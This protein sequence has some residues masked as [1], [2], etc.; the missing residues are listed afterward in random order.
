MAM[1]IKIKRAKGSVSIQPLRPGKL[2]DVGGFSRTSDTK[3]TMGGACRTG[4]LNHKTR[5]LV[6]AVLLKLSPKPLPQDMVSLPPMA[7]EIPKFT[8]KEEFCTAL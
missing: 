5:F 8:S 4:D 2:L 1:M 3:D 7:D 6:A